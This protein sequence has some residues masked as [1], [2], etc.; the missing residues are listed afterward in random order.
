[1]LGLRLAGRSEQSR[2]AHSGPR[3]QH[4]DQGAA[5]PPPSPLLRDALVVPVALAALGS[6]G[7]LVFIG[8]QWFQGVLHGSLADRSGG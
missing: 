5:I 7:L 3:N 8:L 6:G 1:M 4:H 2:A